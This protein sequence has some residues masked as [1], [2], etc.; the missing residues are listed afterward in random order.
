MVELEKHNTDNIPSHEKK[1]D[2]GNKI[3]YS[4][5]SKLFKNTDPLINDPKSI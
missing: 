3:T 2:E 5:N 4:E 1:L